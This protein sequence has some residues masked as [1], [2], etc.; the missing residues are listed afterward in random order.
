[1][2]WDVLLQV[3]L[4]HLMWVDPPLDTVLLTVPSVV[5]INPVNEDVWL[6]ERLLWKVT[7]VPNRQI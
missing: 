4:P 5:G 1:M 6:V 3:D 2:S 7:L